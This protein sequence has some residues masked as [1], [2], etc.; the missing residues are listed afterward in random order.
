MTTSTQY[1]GV[2]A[3]A[4]EKNVRRI[5]L[6]LAVLGGLVVGLLIGVAL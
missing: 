1:V 2:G 6:T 3:H 4:R 5:T